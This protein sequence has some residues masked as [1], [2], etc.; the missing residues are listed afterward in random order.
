[1][2]YLTAPQRHSSCQI[3]IY[4]LELTSPVSFA[5]IPFQEMKKLCFLIEIKV[6]ENLGSMNTLKNFSILP[7]CGAEIPKLPKRERKTS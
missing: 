1:M 3:D 2:S 4:S 7:C 6:G 5:E